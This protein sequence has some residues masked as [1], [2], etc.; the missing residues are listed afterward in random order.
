MTKVNS[1]KFYSEDEGENGLCC[2]CGNQYS[3]FGNNPAPL[4]EKGRCCNDCN[5]D[6]IRARLEQIK[7]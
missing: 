1:K 2:L 3:H 7:K 6:V 5:E 4:K